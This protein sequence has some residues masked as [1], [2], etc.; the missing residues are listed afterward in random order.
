MGCIQLCAQTADSAYSDISR[1]LEGRTSCVSGPTKI[2]TSIFTI[3]AGYDAIRDEYVSP[4]GYS[5]AHFRIGYDNFRDNSE[6]DWN[7]IIAAGVDYSLTHN[8][9]G[10]HTMHS[11]MADAKWATMHRWSDMPWHKFEVMVGPMAQFR[12][13]VLYNPNNSNNVASA[14]IHLAAGV[15]AMATYNTFLWKHSLKLAYEMTLP[16][17]GAFFS[18]EYD[19][20]YYEIYLGNRK[21]LAHFGWWGNRFDITN[22]LYADYAISRNTVLRV[23]Y[24][25]RIETSRVCNISTRD[26]SHAFVIG[27]GC[28]LFS[29]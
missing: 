9:A 15:N 26:I 12:G 19:E 10:N 21:N 14:K 28:N 29:Y 13:G 24:R 23:G 27:I 8:P 11:L 16:V 22:Y 5:G 18:P 1:A 6:S 2:T 17:I 25:N 4:V 7:R 20:A 3:D